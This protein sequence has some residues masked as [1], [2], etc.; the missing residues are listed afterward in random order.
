MGVP[1]QPLQQ[2]SNDAGGRLPLL[3]HHCHDAGTQVSKHMS[4]FPFT[5]SLQECDHV[6][7]FAGQQDRSHEAL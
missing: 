3:N 1:P 2:R 5:Y 4:L 7:V 6:F